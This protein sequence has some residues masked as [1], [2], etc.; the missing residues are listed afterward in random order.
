MKQLPERVSP[1]E[2]IQ[3]GN[4]R[5]QLTPRSRP[6]FPL[7]W[8]LYMGLAVGAIGLSILLLR[9]A[10]LRVDM[11][12]V[13]RGTL[14][15][16]VDAEGKTRVRDRFVIA[17]GTAGHLDRITLN[18]GDSVKSGMVVARIDPLPLNASIQQALGR[19]SEW[20]AQRAGVALSDQT[21]KRCNRLKRKLRRPRHGSARQ[22]HGWQKH[23]QRYNRP[24]AIASGHRICSP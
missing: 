19:L 22:K 6:R 9:P 8:L 24:N 3:I 17:A 16:T 4:D 10:P 11:G 23:G 12:T 1:R 21:L 2:P 14:Q 20:K 5:S 13:Q 7:K 18:E 15:V